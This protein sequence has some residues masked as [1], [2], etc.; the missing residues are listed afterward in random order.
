ML[1]YTKNLKFFIGLKSIYDCSSKLILTAMLLFQGFFFSAQA[2]IVV[3]VSKPSSGVTGVTGTFT[4]PG[5]LAYKVRIT[6]KG[7]KGG[8]ANNAQDQIGGNG[9]VVVGEFDL[10]SGQIIE[11]VAGSMGENYTSIGVVA[12]AV[13]AVR[14]CAL[15]TLQRHSLS[16]AAAAAAVKSLSAVLQMQWAA[17]EMAATAVTV[18]LVA[19]D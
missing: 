2:Q 11:Y 17:L 7:A 9:A 4:V 3:N 8:T 19:A 18:V 6:A 16:R 1:V 10:S 15:K 12:Q 13:A 14:A 5:G